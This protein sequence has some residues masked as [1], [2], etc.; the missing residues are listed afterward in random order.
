MTTP[1]NL[2]RPAHPQR[3]A[4]HVRAAPCTAFLRL[5]L[6]CAACLALPASALALADVAA[7]W[8]QVKPQPAPDVKPVTLDPRTTALLVLD[9]ESN[10][11]NAATRPRCL[12][13]VDAIGRLLAKA[14]QAGAYVAHSVTRRGTPAD[15]LPGAAPRE[16]EPVV[17]SSVN[18]FLQTDLGK[19]LADAGIK[20]VVVV[21]TA[22]HGAVL[23][24]ATHAAQTGMNVV[25]PVDGLSAETLEA[26]AAAVE[27]LRSGPATK[28]VTVFTRADQVTFAK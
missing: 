16:G 10:T 17:A 4:R 5:A 6:L 15:I 23:H 27:V 12:E 18:K 19:L 1:A 26:E 3:P 8:S 2:P 24:T 11:C 20:T 21:G 13:T 9:I 22:A 14:R 28:A 7:Q 25:I